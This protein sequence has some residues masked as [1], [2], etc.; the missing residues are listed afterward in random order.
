MKKFLLILILTSASIHAMDKSVCIAPFNSDTQGQ[1]V[2]DIYCKALPGFIVPYELWHSPDLNHPTKKVDILMRYANDTDAQNNQNGTPIGLAYYTK[3][4]YPNA[5][6]SFF[7]SEQFKAYSAEKKADAARIQSLKN[8]TLAYV[9][10]HAICIQAAYQNKGYGKLLLQHVEK[11]AKEC[12]MIYVS[13]LKGQETWYQKLGYLR[14]DLRDHCSLAKPFSLD[15][16]IIIKAIAAI[17]KKPTTQ[18]IDNGDRPAKKLKETIKEDLSCSGE[19][20]AS[21]N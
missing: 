20:E 15:A 12:D 18:N 17:A 16:S 19:K 2:R 10:L 8:N 13:C 4:T 3:S 9:G 5:Y 14:D 6:R 11:Y 21:C 1:A 7:D